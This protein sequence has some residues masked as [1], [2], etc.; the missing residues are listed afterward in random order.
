MKKPFDMKLWCGFSVTTE[1][2]PISQ[3]FSNFKPPRRR[4]KEKSAVGNVEASWWRHSRIIQLLRQPF[5]S[6]SPSAHWLMSH[7]GFK[8]CGTLSPSSIVRNSPQ[9]STFAGLL[10]RKNVESQVQQQPRLTFPIRRPHYAMFHLR[11]AAYWMKI[12]F[13][14][15][16]VIRLFT[17][18]SFPPPHDPSVH[19]FISS[20]ISMCG[21][22]M[23]IETTVG[24][25]WW[26]R[27]S[28][29]NRSITK[30]IF[31]LSE[32]FYLVDDEI[33]NRAYFVLK[34]HFSHG[35]A[36]F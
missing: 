27:K 19:P 17:S 31:I 15:R 14:F 29:P 26:K 23:S 28:H 4:D 34:T 32:F 9:S 11:L 12:C 13:D 22:F 16:N 10:S 20:Y 25:W 21:G 1:R 6:F 24:G 7:L 2:P 18:R 5:P 36:V 8:L 3:I 30:R 33:S 35:R